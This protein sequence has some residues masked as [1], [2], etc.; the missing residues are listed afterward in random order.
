MPI[1]DKSRYPL[2]DN[3][4]LAGSNAF[5]DDGPHDRQSLSP[6]VQVLLVDALDRRWVQSQR[7]DTAALGHAEV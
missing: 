6:S 7:V 2:V 4:E 5:R 1:T 3:P